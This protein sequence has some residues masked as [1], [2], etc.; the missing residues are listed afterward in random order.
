[1][2]KYNHHDHTLSKPRTIDCL[3]ARCNEDLTDVVGGCLK[4]EEVSDE[5]RNLVYHRS[6]ACMVILIKKRKDLKKYHTTIYIP[7]KDF[8][9]YK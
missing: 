5:L 4:L 8:K 1:M 2:S 9:R 7:K 3:R 6:P